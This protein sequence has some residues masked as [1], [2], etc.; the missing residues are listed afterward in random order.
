MGRDQGQDP[1]EFG[2]EASS[3]EVERSVVPPFA[4]LRF[5]AGLA[6]EAAKRRGEDAVALI[7]DVLGVAQ[8]MGEAGLPALGPA[9]LGAA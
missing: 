5:V 8:E 9:G 1:V 7:N 6:D 3:V 4:L 2:F